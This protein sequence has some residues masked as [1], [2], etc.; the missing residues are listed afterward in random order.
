MISGIYA[1]LNISNEKVYVGSAVK[2]Y[3]RFAYHKNYLLRN[4]H[5][6]KY[7]QNAWNKYGTN[8]F[9]FT[10]LEL[11][12][13]KT[14]LIER[15]QFYINLLKSYDRKFGYNLS[16]TAGSPLG[17]KHTELTK[18]KVS[19]AG[20]GRKFSKETRL[21]IAIGNSGKT[22]SDEAKFKMAQAKLGKISNRRK[23]EKWP[24]PNA[25]RCKCIECRQKTNTMRK[26]RRNK[27]ILV[28]E[29]CI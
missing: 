15:E 4:T 16:P 1:I 14:K 20:K 7:L 8:G 24:H 18:A 25:A 6:N 13:D 19:E 3:Y 12:D 21:K 5:Y 26:A 9:I 23:L 28:E 2:L 17:V 10:I 29:A 27:Y 22:M 11:V